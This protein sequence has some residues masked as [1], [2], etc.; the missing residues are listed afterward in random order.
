MPEDDV[1]YGSRKKR[2]ADS[3]K[4]ET[5]CRL[6]RDAHNRHGRHWTLYNLLSVD[7]RASRAEIL[8][9]PQKVYEKLAPL[10]V[11]EMLLI[12]MAVG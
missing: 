10:A 4:P 5:I 3:P 1:L 2:K 6:Q 9:A 7:S 12:G 11:D 8:K